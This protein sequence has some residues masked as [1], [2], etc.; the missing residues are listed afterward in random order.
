MCNC[1]IWGPKTQTGSLKDLISFKHKYSEC[2]S[3]LWVVF[4]SV[5]VCSPCLV[6]HHVNSEEVWLGFLVFTYNSVSQQPQNIEG[7]WHHLCLNKQINLI[8]V[9]RFWW[10]ANQCHLAVAKR[11]N[12]NTFCLLYH[13]SWLIVLY[14]SLVCQWTRQKL[15]SRSFC[16]LHLS[17]TNQPFLVSQRALRPHW[18]F[19]QVSE[20]IPSQ[21]FIPLFK[22]ASCLPFL[23]F[24]K[25]GRDEAS[26]FAGS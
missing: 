17:V 5:A 13:C 24:K 7:D 2:F 25:Y 21:V 3:W 23:S 20:I 8:F 6:F 15:K 18:Y 9:R 22:T 14:V 26:V 1:L 19:S 4:V 16:L 11:S 10:L 12:N